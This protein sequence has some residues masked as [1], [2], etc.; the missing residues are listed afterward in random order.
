MRIK[1]RLATP[2]D[3]EALLEIYAPYVKQTAISFECDVP[4]AAEF[5]GRIEKTLQRYPYLLAYVSDEAACADDERDENF[6]ISASAAGAGNEISPVNKASNYA[7]GA[8]KQNGANLIV[9][10][11][12][13]GVNL[14]P[15][16]ILGY[17]YASVFK[18][19]A[20]YDWSAESSVYVSQN[21][22]VLGIGR[23]LYEALQRALGAQNIADMNA[24]I[25][26][27][28][29]EYLNDASVRFHERMS[30]RFVGKFERC[31]YK[32]GRWYDM[33]WMQKPIGEHLQNQPAMRPFARFRDEI[34]ASAGIEI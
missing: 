11:K 24:C 20:A 4:G 7:S 29:D 14:K 23:L 28:D 31:A 10:A 34:C 3:A 22:R 16:Q 30:F 9:A 21:V 6:K 27:G 1:L 15:G 13:S 2:Q 26:C 5:A 17:A 25:A 12:Q 8:A 32:F 18:E 33:A 19:R